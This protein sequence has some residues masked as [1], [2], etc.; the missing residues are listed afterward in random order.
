[1]KKRI[2]CIIMACLVISLMTGCG[3]K[4][5]LISE[6]IPES[7]GLYT[8]EEG[9]KEEETEEE[10]AEGQETDVGAEPETI[11]VHVCGAVNK[12][13]VYEMPAESRIYEAVAAAG[14]FRADA[15]QDYLNMAYI[16]EDGTKLEVPTVEEIAELEESEGALDKRVPAEMAKSVET[17]GAG[18]GEDA[19]LVNINTAGVAELCG[20]S[21]IGE[22][23]A[24]AIL[25]YREKNGKFQKK[26]D[27]MQVSGIG[28]KM[29][30]KIKDNITV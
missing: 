23:R 13:G 1:M 22:S 8:E 6:L 7:E 19:N 21:G 30:E 27:I 24:E 2:S 20:L 14:G 3:K 15:A 18:T 4:L 9:I 11:F 29:F 10:K 25:E 12:P 5:E 17:V 26:E 16:L 28:Q